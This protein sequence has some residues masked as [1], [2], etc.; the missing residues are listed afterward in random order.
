MDLHK[1]AGQPSSKEACVVVELRDALHAQNKLRVERLPAVKPR[2][3]TE[4]AMAYLA[5]IID[6][7]GHVTTRGR[8]DVW[9]TDPELIA[10]LGGL[11]GSCAEVTPK[12]PEQERAIY[13]W[14][15]K[16]AEGRSLLTA[17]DEHI[18]VRRKSID[19]V[20]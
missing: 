6:G 20:D 1:R 16:Q 3:R 5:G 7:E 15:T 4:Q 14:W 11:G 18:L 17:A 13:R 19:A 9:S 2:R 10:W 8:L 12:K